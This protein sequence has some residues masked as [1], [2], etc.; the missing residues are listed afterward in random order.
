MRTII[1]PTTQNV[2]IE[3]E[4]AG[5][6]TR[7]FA[8]CLDAL[9]CLG[10]YLIMLATF[11][12]S[13]NYISMVVYLPLTLFLLYYFT[14]ELFMGGQ[15]FGKNI[16]GL[17]VIRADGKQPTP[18]DFLL[19]T[20]F[21]L[22]DVWFSMGI[23]AVLLVNTTPRAQRLGDMVAHTVV[24]RTRNSENLGLA[25]ILNIQTKE[26]YEPQFVQVQQLSE[27]DML[28]VKQVLTRYQRYSN[29]PH[30]RAVQELAS[31]CREQ[32]DIQEESDD[33]SANELLKQLLRDYIVLT[34]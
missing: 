22:P 25:D 12:N 2:S 15:T 20:I 3:Y 17:K 29:P 23:P 1:I 4:L 28:L 13:I 26:D 6:M 5:S 30:L 8:L 33:L 11:G 9:I 27:E 32:L 14:A 24:I 7:I 18:G 34:R 19:R 10:V 21:L 31:R 16:Q